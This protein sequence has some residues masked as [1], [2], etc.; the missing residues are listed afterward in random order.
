LTTF[1]PYDH[2]GYLTNRIGRL[3][4]RELGQ[5]LKS[6]G[7]DFP[8]S[9][10]G[11]L[12]DLWSK[13]GV[14]QK[15]LEIS[16]VKNK[17]TINKM[18]SYLIDEKLIVKKEDIK[19]KRVRYI[20]LTKKGKSLQNIVRKHHDRLNEKLLKKFTQ[21]EITFSKKLLQQCYLF[22]AENKEPLQN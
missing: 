4:S 6:E 9:C 10:I 1:N 13:D 12:A 14:Q 5:T 11:I 3:L 17:S 18:I 16:L 21:E 2:F 20:H 15:D 7:Y 19:D 8:T 22:L